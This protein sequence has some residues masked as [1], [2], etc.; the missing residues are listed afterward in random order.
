MVDAIATAKLETR[1]EGVRRL[2][3]DTGSGT[4]LL[5]TQMQAHD[6]GEGWY[7]DNPLDGDNTGSRKDVFRHMWH[8]TFTPTPPIAQRIQEEF[9]Y[10]GVTPGNYAAAHIRAVYAVKE[11]SDDTIV[12]MTKHAMDC[13]SMLRPG[14]PF[15]V[16]SD[17]DKAI[18]VAKAYGRIKNVTVVASSNHNHNN[19]KDPLH[20][21][22]YNTT[23]PS[24]M[25]EDFYDAF[26]DLYLL[27]STRC[28]AHGQGSFGHWGY[29]LGY[30]PSC[31]IRHFKGPQCAWT[32]G[33]TATA[34]EQQMRVF[35]VASK[36]PPSRPL[37]R[38]PMSY[39]SIYAYRH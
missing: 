39:D 21:D 26:V 29:L 2:A 35:G 11:R 12:R 38:Q 31:E 34:Q 20:L 10:M 9:D 5:A 14:G 18:T 1:P 25:P 16:A 30:D 13:V 15:F 17:T 4:M 33:P 28:I 8:W 7:D 36:E 27:G 23:D 22:M 32:D 3:N 6:Y 24:I 37:F 19:R